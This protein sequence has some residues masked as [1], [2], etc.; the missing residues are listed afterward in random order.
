M[1][2]CLAKSSSLSFH[3]ENTG[4]NILGRLLERS[5]LELEDGLSL[6]GAEAG[7]RQGLVVVV[8]L[9][10][11]SLVLRHS[12]Q[13]LGKAVEHHREPNHEALVRGPGSREREDLELCQIADVDLGLV[14]LI[15]HL[16]REKGR[17]R[18][19]RRTYITWEDG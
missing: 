12:P 5:E 10:N 1:T 15:A 13:R 19:E 7:G 8:V 16:S 9:S 18:Q 14:L 11:T 17:G 2:I 3:L 6:V 4:R